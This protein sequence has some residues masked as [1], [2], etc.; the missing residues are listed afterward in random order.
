MNSSLLRLKEV[1]LY[2]LHL[3]CTGFGGPLA[4]VSMMQQDLAEK[5]KWITTEEF[6]TAISLIKVLPGAFA[7]QTAVF[8]GHRRA[9]IPGG[10]LAG[11]C[12]IFPA[13]LMMC[14]LAAIYDEWG[15]NTYF[16]TLTIGFGIGALALIIYS[17]VQISKPYQKQSL[18]YFC[19]AISFLGMFFQIAPEPVLIL[20]LGFLTWV[21][22]F[23][24]RK[25]SLE[26]GSILLL[27]WIAFKSGAFVF[28]SGLAIAPLLENDF[29]R[30]Q[31]W[32]DLA[33]FM[34]ALAFGQMT[35]GPV[36]VTIT[37]LAFRLGG[38]PAAFAA[39]FFVFLPGYIHMLTWFP[40]FFKKV[41]ASRGFRDFAIGAIGGVI[42]AIT[43]FVVRAFL[44]AN[45]ETNFVSAGPLILLSACLILIAKWKIPS[46][47]IILGSGLVYFCTQI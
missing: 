21:W 32:V 37:F 41:S 23:K 17:L 31:Q 45:G 10:L 11:A 42:G 24:S 35:P 26:A 25:L 27:C 4:L 36:L 20:A 1:A 47:L 28:G 34:T 38:F 39:T 43:V 8:M 19:A 16:K 29:V 6:V 44:P 18:F 9:G 14:G 40:I 12:L 2:F 5:R 22:N 3:G 30:E 13:F 15:G 7:F 46:W 33:T